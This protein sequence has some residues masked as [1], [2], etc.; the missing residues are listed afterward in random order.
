MTLLEVGYSSR[1]RDEHEQLVASAPLSHM[2]L[3]WDIPAAVTR[4]AYEVQGLMAA[5]GHHRAPSIPDLI[6][7]ATAEA[8]SLTVLHHDKDF[9]LIARVTGQPLCRLN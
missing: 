9:D 7:A 6:L 4:R 8:G 1:G 5:S 2:I 3:E